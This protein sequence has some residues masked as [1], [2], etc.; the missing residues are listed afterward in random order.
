MSIDEIQVEELKR[1]AQKAKS[2]GWNVTFKWGIL[3]L[4]GHELHPDLSVSWEKGGESWKL[5]NK[6]ESKSNIVP[7]GGLRYP[8]SI[9]F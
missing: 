6:A 9:H 8:N 7:V 2:N 4:T 1:F 5:L 3:Y